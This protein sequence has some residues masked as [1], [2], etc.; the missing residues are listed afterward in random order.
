[1]SQRRGLGWL[2]A[3]S[4]LVLGLAVVGCQKSQADRYPV[5]G[6]ISI[7][8]EPIRGGFVVFEPT[9]T[10]GGRQGYAKIQDGRFDTRTGGEPAVAGP[11]VVRVQG[12]GTPTDRFPDGVPLCDRYEFRLELQTGSNEL[13][14]KVPESARLKEPRGG[15][16]EGP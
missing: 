3:A 12:W 10:L 6:T 13:E 15:W 4:V 8:S 11:V 16:G 1:M 2:R 9:T 14:L 5:A 7:G